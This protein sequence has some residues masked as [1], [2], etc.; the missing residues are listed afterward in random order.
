MET[1]DFTQPS[2]SPVYDPAA[3]TAFFK[4]AGTAENVAA[5]TA[6]FTEHQ[7]RGFFSAADRM[8]LLLE[9]AVVLSIGGKSIDTVNS[10]EIF[11]EMAT[12]TNSKRSATATAK[13]ACR[14]ISLDG[15]QFQKAIQK[16][17]A[18]VPM[19]M[20][21][22]IDRL[23][24]TLA[25]LAM[26]KALPDKPAV[27]RRVFDDATLDAIT[28]EL[29]NP[30]LLKYTAGQ[31]IIKAGESGVLMYLPRQGRVAITADGKTLERVGPGG[32][33]GEMALV[34][35]ATRAA[36]AVAET[37]CALLAVNRKQFLELVQSNPEIGLS[38]LKVLGQRLQAATSQSAK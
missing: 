13:T 34:D 7:Q 12:I 32:V 3:A 33:F 1:L 9:G 24:L 30:R 26:K 21:I 27:E 29:G 22:M 31:S 36:N 4:A 18:F 23:R 6:F 10:G 14:V 2:Q 35:R 17:P 37:D 5:G 16:S 15:G 28:G 19:L 8:Y 25:R 11:G 20:S 38:L